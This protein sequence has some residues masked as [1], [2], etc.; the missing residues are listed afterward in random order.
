MYMPITII[1]VCFCLFAMCA[2]F[3]VLMY[4]VLLFVFS[5]TTY[6]AEKCCLQFCY[7][8][9]IKFICF[10]LLKQ[11]LAVFRFV[12]LILPYRLENSV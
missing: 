10:L 1:N 3:L 9:Q 5:S 7:L 12:I 2:I 4:Q 11:A 8:S 6:F